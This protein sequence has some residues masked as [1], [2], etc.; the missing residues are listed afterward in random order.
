[1]E[2]KMSTIRIRPTTLILIAAVAAITSPLTVQADVK[3]QEGGCIW[4]DGP[5]TD[6]TGCTYTA[7]NGLQNQAS[8]SCALETSGMTPS[9][10]VVLKDPMDPTDNG[11]AAESDCVMTV[12]VNGKNANPTCTYDEKPDATQGDTGVCTYVQNEGDTVDVRVNDPD[13]GFTPD[14]SSGQAGTMCPAGKSVTDPCS[15]AGGGGGA[16]ALSEVGVVVLGVSLLG[17]GVGIVRHRRRSK[18]S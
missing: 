14:S 9:P 11:D 12:F 16:P 2:G 13:A 10:A 3:G 7:T 4:T 1:M 5:N 6:N 17:L 15:D 8:F 18:S